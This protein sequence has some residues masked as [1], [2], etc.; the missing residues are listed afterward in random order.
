MSCIVW[1]IVAG[2]P[3]AAVWV[4]VAAFSAE[5][6]QRSLRALRAAVCKMAPRT[7]IL[8]AVAKRRRVTVQL[9]EEGEATNTKASNVIDKAA[10]NILDG[11]QE[12]AINRI[13]AELR[14]SPHK[15]L[16]ILF[17]V[18]VGWWGRVGCD[19]GRRW[20]RMVSQT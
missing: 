17:Q 12:Q 1:R 2:A 3:L 5:I 10:S 6:R 15:I 13:V 16:P 20:I 9:N 4:D 7:G 11:S 18:V 8:G 14:K 19:R